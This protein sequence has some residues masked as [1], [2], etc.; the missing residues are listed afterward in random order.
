[1]SFR[2]DPVFTMSDNEHRVSYGPNALSGTRRDSMTFH[3]I[4][5]QLILL[6]VKH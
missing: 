1:M 2:F 3:T 5:Y 6:S 4:N